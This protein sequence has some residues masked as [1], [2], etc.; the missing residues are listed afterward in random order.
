MKKALCRGTGLLLYF[1]K[2]DRLYGTAVFVRAHLAE[3]KKRAR[4]GTYPH[5]GVGFKR[6]FDLFL[7]D[8]TAAAA[9]L[10]VKGGQVDRGQRLKKRFRRQQQCIARALRQRF[11][12]L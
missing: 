1:K 2:F 12:L 3:R 6:G 11:D 5:A 10:F 4:F 9:E 8:L 7:V